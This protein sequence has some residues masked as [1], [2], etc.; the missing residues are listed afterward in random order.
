MLDLQNLPSR[1]VDAGS[2]LWPLDKYNITLLNH[3]HPTGW[4]NPKPNNNTYD[5]VV[6]GAGA[7]GLVTS[8]G[9]AGVGARVALIEAN[10]LGGDCLNVGCV[11]SK[12]LIRAAHLAHTVKHV[13][14]LADSGI[15]ITNGN[16]IEID[17]AKI[18]ERIRRIRAQISHHDSAVRYTR[19]LGV[20]V[21]IGR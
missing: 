14:A 3:V 6:I 20:D 8:S 1:D 13:D 19:E 15:S 2:S 5:L 7:A 4:R 21:F 10:L 9:A 17:F 18:M 11:P 16:I 12:M